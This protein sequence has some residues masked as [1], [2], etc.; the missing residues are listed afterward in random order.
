MEKPSN[1]CFGSNGFTQA[2]AIRTTIL[3]DDITCKLGVWVFNIYRKLKFFL[4]LPHSL[5]SFY[6]HGHGPSIQVHLSP[7]LTPFIVKGP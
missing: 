1:V 7:E 4:I 2:V 6:S 5:S 3:A